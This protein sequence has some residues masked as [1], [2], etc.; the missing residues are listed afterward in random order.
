MKIGEL[1]EI[2]KIGKTSFARIATLGGAS[3]AR[4]TTELAGTCQI[5]NFA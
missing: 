5:L 1:R 2:E 3:W 4:L